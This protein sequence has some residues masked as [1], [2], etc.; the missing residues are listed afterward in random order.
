MYAYFCVRACTRNDS[1]SPDAHPR[2]TTG[3]D[4]ERDGEETVRNRFIEWISRRR[5]EPIRWRVGAI[6]ASVASYSI[7]SES[8]DT[9]RDECNM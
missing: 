2:A 3:R 1:E 4:G 5:L 8:V 7:E 9:S 6:V